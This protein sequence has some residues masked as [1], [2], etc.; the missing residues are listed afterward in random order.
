MRIN[1]T[2]V[3]SI[4]AETG[5]VWYPEEATKERIDRDGYRRYSFKIK[6]LKVNVKTSPDTFKLSF[7]PGTEVI[8]EVAGLYY[9]TG[10][11]DTD[12][13]IYGIVGNNNLTQLKTNKEPIVNQNN[14]NKTFTILLFVISGIIALCVPVFYVGRKL[15]I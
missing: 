6:S 7:P 4:E 1:V 12:Q 11:T 9:T 10:G 5:T 2:K 13:S 8:D 3:G 15:M 14:S